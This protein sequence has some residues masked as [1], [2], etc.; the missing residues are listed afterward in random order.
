MIELIVLDVDGCLTNGAITYTQSGD[1]IKSFDVKDGLA[2]ATWIKMGKTVA[3][4]TGR[5]SKIVQKRADDLKINLVYQ[6][7]KDKKKKLDEI[8]EIEGISYANIAVIGDDLN[9]YH[10]LKCAKLSFTPK[11]GVDFIKE[12]VDITLS[13]KGGNGAVREMIEII[14]KE[15]N[16][17]ERFLQQWL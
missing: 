1:E 13:K 11:N 7:I 2:I 9:D 3:I 10:M 8:L 4:I 6:G 16:L 5:N 12:T 14:I 17:Q 15:Q